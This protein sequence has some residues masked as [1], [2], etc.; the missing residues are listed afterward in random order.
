[1]ELRA[2]GV[3]L[4]HGLVYYWN[5]HT[6]QTQWL[7]VDFAEEEDDVVDEYGDQGVQDEL[8]EEQEEEEATSRLPP[9]ILPRRVCRYV[10]IWPCLPVW[11]SMHV[12]S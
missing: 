9:L 1:M 2:E 8:V 6:R 11:H 3:D 5:V 10:I 7:L 4:D 12:R